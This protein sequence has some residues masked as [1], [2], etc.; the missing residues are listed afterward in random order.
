MLFRGEKCIFSLI[1]GKSH[2]WDP[3]RFSKS[4]IPGQPPRWCKAPDPAQ[5]AEACCP[6]HRARLASAAWAVAV[7]WSTTLPFVP[8]IL[9]A[10]DKI[11]KGLAACNLR[12]N[13][14]R[15]QIKLRENENVIAQEK[16]EQA[17]GNAAFF[18]SIFVFS[19][20]V[21]VCF[22]SLLLR[23]RLLFLALI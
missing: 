13:L 4:Y 11:F 20:V 6:R 1:L 8:W 10:A 12:M 3:S 15:S 22:L 14:V 18:T 9:K 23:Q 21:F 7:S 5:R 16:N 19:L 17:G 2:T